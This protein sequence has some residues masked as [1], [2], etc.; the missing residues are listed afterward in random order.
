M[1]TLEGA[2]KIIT[3]TLRS[4]SHT[5]PTSLKTTKSLCLPFFVFVFSTRLLYWLRV[6]C[7]PRINQ[8]KNVIAHGPLGD[9]VAPKVWKV[10]SQIH[11]SILDVH[12][13]GFKITYNHR[14]RSTGTHATPNQFRLLFDVIARIFACQISEMWLVENR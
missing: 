6:S 7:T 11:N 13:N 2:Q 8:V 1:I 10:S 12:D 4:F 5:N 9:K 3:I 14:T